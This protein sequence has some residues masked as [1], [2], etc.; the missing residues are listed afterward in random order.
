MG[1]NFQRTGEQTMIIENLRKILD[2]EIEPEF[3]KHHREN[4][5][6]FPREL[7]TKWLKTLREF[8]VMTAPHDEKWGGFAMDWLTN[9]MVFEE[10]AYTSLDIA[11][12]GFINSVGVAFLDQHASE[13]NRSAVPVQGGSQGLPNG[14]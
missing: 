6:L 11:I 8:G 9:L 14:D 3:L 1:M 4:G 2:N 12:P 10:V 5:G 13:R 7:I